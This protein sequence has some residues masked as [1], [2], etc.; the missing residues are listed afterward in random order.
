MSNETVGAVIET[1][2]RSSK[3]LA[4]GSSSKSPISQLRAN[5]PMIDGQVGGRPGDAGADVEIEVDAR[6]DLGC[7]ADVAAHQVAERDLVRRAARDVEAEMGA[8]DRRVAD[9]VERL[10]AEESEPRR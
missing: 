10:D 4:V 3:V 8:D 5:V 2:V 7:Q 6:R 9:A 1:V